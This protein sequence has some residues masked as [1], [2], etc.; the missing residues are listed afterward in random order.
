MQPVRGW[1]GF[2]A[3]NEVFYEQLA[4][5]WI[6]PFTISG[7]QPLVFTLGGFSVGF[8]INGRWFSVANFFSHWRLSIKTTFTVIKAS[9][10]CSVL[11]HAS[12]HF[13]VTSSV[14]TKYLTKLQQT[15]Y[16]LG[17][18]SQIFTA[19]IWCSATTVITSII[20][21]G[22]KHPLYTYPLLK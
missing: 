7:W 20:Q 9:N 14:Q 2:L 19:W 4:Y 10:A 21:S 3:G 6:S 1:H 11:Q 5:S 16:G 8:C 22:M 18:L 15:L 17:K 12:K 13:S